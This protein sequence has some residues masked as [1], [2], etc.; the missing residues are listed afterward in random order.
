MFGRLECPAAIGDKNATTATPAIS[1]TTL[2]QTSPVYSSAGCREFQ[3][4]ERRM[5]ELKP[6]NNTDT[7]TIEKKVRDGGFYTRA[8]TQTPPSS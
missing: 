8:D 5:S 3:F 7:C 1:V 2:T 4:W 6:Y